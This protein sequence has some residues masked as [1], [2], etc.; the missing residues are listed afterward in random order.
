MKFF[1]M[2]KKMIRK[3]KFLTIAVLFCAG[4]LVYII[5]GCQ[6]LHFEAI[7][8]FD[9]SEEAD[10]EGVSCLDPELS[11]DI[12]D[13]DEWEEGEDTDGDGDGDRDGTD[14]D[15]DGDRDRDGTDSDRDG[16][17]NGTGTGRDGD[18]DGT[19][20]D[21]NDDAEPEERDI[22]YSRAT[23]ITTK[24]GRIN[25]LF[26]VDN[27]GSM[28]E[29]LESIANQF[30]SFLSS[31]K[32]ADYRIAITTTDWIEDRGRF[33]EFP[34]GEIF[35]SN[36]NRHGSK[37]NENVRLFQE[38]V[39][40]PIGNMDDERGI[41]SLNMALDNM[42]H[43][44]F[45]RPHSLFM[46]IMISDEDERSYGGQVP[47]GLYGTV[48]ELEP[49]DLPETFF[50]KV[51]HQ[52]KYSIVSVHSIIVPPGD[53]ACRAQSGGVEG[54][55]YAQLSQPSSEIL[56]K[57]GNIRSG[58]IGSVCSSNYSSQLGPIADTLSEVPPVSLPCF[59][60]GEVFF[61]VDGRRVG[62]RVEGRQLIITEDEV[63]FGAKARIVFRCKPTN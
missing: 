12:F 51:S 5:I 23:A 42:D 30:D 49:Y 8:E 18:R 1:A 2:I 35:L 41:Y 34:N 60:K 37:H 39:K 27:S 10:V 62:Y 40:R 22:S 45:F 6:E 36:P 15:R 28:K 61:E 20:T 29:E 44:D 25:I 9:C 43:A 53:S 11:A 17:R 50:R 14:S 46:V 32:K 38:T 47:E 48:P 63:S 26:V 24:L 13:E 3:V 21:A 56:S 4:F 55:I 16:D 54:R 57:Y 52:I 58:H 31:I 59:P 19:D 7:P 33:L